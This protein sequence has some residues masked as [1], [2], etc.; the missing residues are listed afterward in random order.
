LPDVFLQRDKDLAQ[1]LE[2]G[3]RPLVG[4]VVSQAL[5]LG[6]SEGNLCAD[7]VEIRKKGPDL[8]IEDP[9]NQLQEVV[10]CGEGRFAADVVRKRRRARA[11]AILAASR[12]TFD[13]MNT[14]LGA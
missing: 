1:S 2:V 8:W 12:R 6:L 11:G 10:A 9:R 7:R 4:Q 14:R 3:F 13:E 5:Y